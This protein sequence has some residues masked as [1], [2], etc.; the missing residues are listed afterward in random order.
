M[1]IVSIYTRTSEGCVLGGSAI[2]NGNTRPEETGRVAAEDFLNSAS[3]NDRTCVDEYLQDQV[4]YYNTH[5]IIR[6][7]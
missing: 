1:I 3:R 4:N 7:L 6:H 5:N 2:G